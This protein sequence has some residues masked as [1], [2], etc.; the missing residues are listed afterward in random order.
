MSS[1]PLIDPDMLIED[2]LYG[3]S[4]EIRDIARSQL[5]QK[6]S[7]KQLKFI[8]HALQSQQRIT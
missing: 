8:V 3:E 6:A 2:L 5:Q 7:K 1:S 4:I